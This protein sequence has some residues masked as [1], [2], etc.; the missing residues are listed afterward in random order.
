MARIITGTAKNKYKIKHANH[1]AGP[2]KI[3]CPFCKTGICIEAL[4]ATGK[5]IMRCQQCGREYDFKNM[6]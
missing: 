1:P 5:K 4:T 2:A 3:R 6:S